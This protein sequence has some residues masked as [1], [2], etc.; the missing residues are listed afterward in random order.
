MQQRKTRNAVYEHSSLAYLRLYDT[1]GSHD[2]T[3]DFVF[4][5]FLLR[6]LFYKRMH[7]TLVLVVHCEGVSNR[8]Y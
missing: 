8:Q 2:K 3:T 1:S 6:R 7:V 5:G 4:T